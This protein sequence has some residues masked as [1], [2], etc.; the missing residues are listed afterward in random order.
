ML[1]NATLTAPCRKYLGC[2][3]PMLTMSNYALSRVIAPLGWPKS[4]GPWSKSW[5]FFAGLQWI[6]TLNCRVS[7]DFSMDFNI[8][9]PSQK[10]FQRRFCA[11]TAAAQRQL[12]QAAPRCAMMA[13]GHRRAPAA[14][15]GARWGIR[16]PGMPGMPSLGWPMVGECLVVGEA[17]GQWWVKSQRFNKY[18]Q[19][20]WFQMAFLHPFQDDQVDWCA[21]EISKQCLTC[22]RYL[23]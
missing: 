6:S 12:S 1:R 3:A 10:W 5:F 9:Q 17:S 19:L 16:L 4:R 14:V 11:A 15:S 13:S 21:V 22:G 7:M 20:G 8:I 2:R 18:Q 23:I